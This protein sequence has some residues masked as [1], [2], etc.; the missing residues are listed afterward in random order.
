ME[1]R[2][3]EVGA[4]R[5]RELDQCHAALVLLQETASARIRD[6]EQVCMCVC[7]RACVCV[8]VCVCVCMCVCAHVCVRVCECV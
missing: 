4:M 3:K 6:L 1:A 8:C 7:V 5:M 2:D